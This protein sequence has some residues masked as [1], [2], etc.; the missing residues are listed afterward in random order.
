MP[1][2]SHL[3]TQ[4]GQPRVLVGDYSMPGTL[5]HR[6]TLPVSKKKKK[7]KKVFIPRLRHPISLSVYCKLV[8]ASNQC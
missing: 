3:T 8:V 2:L 4:L 7:K 6:V 1:T 5:Q